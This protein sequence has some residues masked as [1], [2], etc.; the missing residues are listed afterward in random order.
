MILLHFGMN[1]LNHDNGIIN[2][3]TD[4]KHQPEQCQYINGEPEKIHKKEGSNNSNRYGNGGYNSRTQILKKDEYDQKNKKKR[5][6]KG[7][8]HL[9][10]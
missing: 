4:G 3:N 7:M 10:D 1:R 2:N 8:F 5:F 6:N 9:L